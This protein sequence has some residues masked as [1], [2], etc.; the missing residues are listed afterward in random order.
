[1]K[2]YILILF[3]VVFAIPA[4]SQWTQTF[5]NLKMYRVEIA[6]IANDEQA[7]YL[8]RLIS[9]CNNV[10]IARIYQEGEGL[11]FTEGEIDFNEIFEKIAKV[12]NVQVGERYQVTPNKEDYITTYC[13]FGLIPVKDIENTIPS[14]LKINDPQK[15]SRAHSVMKQLW[16][17]KYPESHKR[18]MPASNEE[19]P[20][21]KQQ[22]EKE[23][24]NQKNN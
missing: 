7:L 15:Q 18:L 19:D 21:V 8:S 17:E 1:M 22:K 11:I 3:L 20:L 6:G 12:Q 10:L 24:Y 9:E 13:N 16:V 14:P 2:K 4:M 23:L 5:E